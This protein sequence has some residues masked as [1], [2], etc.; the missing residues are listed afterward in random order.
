MLV[1]RPRSV[2]P[3]SK[4]EH[5]QDAFICFGYSLLSRLMLAGPQLASAVRNLPSRGGGWHSFEFSTLRCKGRDV[6]EGG[7]VFCAS[8]SKNVTKNAPENWVKGADFSLFF[9]NSVAVLVFV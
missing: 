8:L 9:S 7:V 6:G 2:A 4:L 5:P 3:Q 1:V